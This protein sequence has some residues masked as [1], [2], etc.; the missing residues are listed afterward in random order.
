MDIIKRLEKWLEKDQIV[1]RD[2]NEDGFS[3]DG[4]IELAIE[5]IKRLRHLTTNSHR[6]HLRIGI[7][8]RHEFN[9]RDGDISQTAGRLYFKQR[10][11]DEEWRKKICGKSHTAR[12]AEG[13]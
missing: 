7:T 3:I 11:K 4:D 12:L 8:E 10:A 2:W 5:E 13:E 6:D 9:D 1:A